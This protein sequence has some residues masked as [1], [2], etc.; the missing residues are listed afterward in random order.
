MSMSAYLLLLFA[1]V[2]LPSVA[3]AALFADL[4]NGDIGDIFAVAYN[5]D[6]SLL[7]AAGKGGVAVWQ[8]STWT[9]IQKLTDHSEHVSTLAF[10]PEGTYLATGSLDLTVGIWSTSTWE[11]ETILSGHSK[12]VLS[13]AWS[14]DGSR[15]ASGGADWKAIIWSTSSWDSE[16]TLVQNNNGADLMEFHSVAF[17]PDGTKLAACGG[18]SFTGSTDN[19]VRIYSTTT[20]TSVEVLMGEHARRIEYLSWNPDGSRLATASLDGRVKLWST[21]EWAEIVELEDAER[22]QMKSVAWSPDGK[23]LAAPSSRGA[24]IWDATTFAHTVLSRIHT[25]AVT[26]VA[27]DSRG[28]RIASGSSDDTVKV[29][30]IVI[31]GLPTTS[32]AIAPMKRTPNPTAAPRPPTTPTAEMPTNVPTQHGTENPIVEQLIT[33]TERSTYSSQQDA[34]LPAS[35]KWAIFGSLVGFVA[36]AITLY[37]AIRYYQQPQQN[38]QAGHNP[39][40]VIIQLAPLSHQQQGP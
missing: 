33:E 27:F 37:Q 4:T 10:N 14:P 21:D 39:Q 40:P 35:E 12:S 34:G 18:A 28:T 1:A 16:V 29:S 2:Q 17:S 38:Q 7:A 36:A 15:L 20:W 8:T 32:P 3:F 25:D 23:L 5:A 30:G 11:R 13:L 26:T 31:P 22:F 19:Q 24:N 9:L 6:S